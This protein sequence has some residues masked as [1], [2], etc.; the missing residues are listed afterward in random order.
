MNEM[1]L[2]A[3]IQVIVAWYPIVVP[4][5]VVIGSPIILPIEIP[6]KIKV[7][8]DCISPSGAISY[9]NVSAIATKAGYAIA[10][11]ILNINAI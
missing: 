2:I 5:N 8:Y 6:S 1:K 10:G 11:I 7:I 3:K 4:I 9:V